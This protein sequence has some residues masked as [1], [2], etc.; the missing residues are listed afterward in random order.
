M[1]KAVLGSLT[2]A[3]VD[4]LDLLVKLGVSILV[5]VLVGKALRELVKPIR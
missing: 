3:K 4:S 5:P 2:D 1:V